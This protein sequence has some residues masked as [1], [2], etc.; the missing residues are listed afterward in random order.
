MTLF[1]AI[2]QIAKNFAADFLNPAARG[3][4]L[5]GYISPDVGSMSLAQKVDAVIN[6]APYVFIGLGLIT[7]LRRLRKRQFHSA[8][9][10]LS[11]PA[12]LIL[13]MV[14]VVPY[15]APTFLADRF[16]QVTLVFLAPLVVLGGQ[17]FFGWV[18]GHL[19]SVMRRRRVHMFRWDLRAMSV[20]LVIILLFKV[21]FVYEVVA[22]VPQST[23]ISFA[24]M[25][26]SN[27]AMLKY[28]FYSDYVPEQDVLGARWLSGL[29]A[30]V[31]VYADYLS[32]AKVLRAYGMRILPENYEL[33][34]P[35]RIGQNGYVYL[36]Y[37]NV[38]EGI[39]ADPEGTGFHSTTIRAAIV[40]WNEIY[41]NGGAEIF[42][43]AL[44][45][46]C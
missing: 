8:Y 44:T 28:R 42:E 9:G 7:V 29:P 18:L 34:D 43:N 19:N 10:L 38:V 16:Y 32:S 3:G 22:D 17:T 11:L 31:P 33:S 40:T 27:D 35:P 6:K 20:L 24:R 37:L 26:A 12:V 1:D 15:L 14:L 13:S 23:S 46:V 39:I 5:M 41:S 45:R 30:C 2:R 25:S 36:S 4:E 21:G